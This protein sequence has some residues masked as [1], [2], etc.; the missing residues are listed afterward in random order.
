M[1]RLFWAEVLILR[2][3]I[4]CLIY[5]WY[6]MWLI[7]IATFGVIFVY[8]SVKRKIRHN[9]YDWSYTKN[10]VK[11]LLWRWGNSDTIWEII[12]YKLGDN[13]D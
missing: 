3:C 9:F 5:G 6:D 1:I 7:L 11:H 2:A 4:P 8:Y 10:K 13:N 12:E